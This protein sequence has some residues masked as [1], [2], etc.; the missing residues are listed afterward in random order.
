[1]IVG[2]G[3]E[4]SAVV[5]AKYVHIESIQAGWHQ[6]RVN[7]ANA[8]AYAQTLSDDRDRAT[9]MPNARNSRPT[10]RC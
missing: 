9:A 4:S 8:S 6:R 2:L 5:L 1:L 7:A 3:S 10:L